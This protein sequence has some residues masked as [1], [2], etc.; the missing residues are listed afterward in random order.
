MRLYDVCHGDNLTHCKAPCVLFQGNSDTYHWYDGWFPPN[1]DNKIPNEVGDFIREVL[2]AQ[3]IIDMGRLGR[4]TR[5]R[6]S[7]VME[8]ALGGSI[9]T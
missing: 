5:P 9:V 3:E 6:N 8:T 2:K 1:S 4:I 7:F